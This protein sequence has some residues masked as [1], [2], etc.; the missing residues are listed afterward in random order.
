MRGGSRRMKYLV[1]IVGDKAD[2]AHVLPGK[3]HAEL[4]ELLEGLCDA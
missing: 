4:D 1:A 3:V 2:G